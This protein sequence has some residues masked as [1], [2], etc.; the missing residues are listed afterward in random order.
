MNLTTKYLGFELRNPLIVSSCRLSEKIDN[1]V[2]MEK[3]GA[4]AITMY[5]IFE[6]EIKNTDEFNEYFLNL[7][8]ES[9]YEALTYFPKL[10]NKKSFLNQHLYHLAQAVK[11]VSIPIIGSLNA[12]THQGWIDYAVEMQN[13]GIKAL[14]LNLYHLPVEAHQAAD[15]EQ[16]QLQLIAELK[17][18]IQIPL[19][20]K[21]SPYYTSLK[22][23]V[24]KLDK[25]VHVDG[26]VLFNRFYYPQFDVKSFKF[27]SDIELSTSYEARLPM[28]WIALLQ[29][30]LA[31]SIAG[32]T[33]V[34]NSDDL[35]TYLLVG[36]DAVACASCLMQNGIGYIKVLLEGLEAWMKEHKYIELSQINRLLSMQVTANR[37][38]IE[39]AQYMEA[40]RSYRS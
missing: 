9:F 5:S 31:C 23:F 14:E 6:E 3:A 25:Q 13:T 27:H 4:G 17:K 24:S 7:G 38:A 19:A 39:R 35:L 32:S 1:I 18:K 37:L 12:I 36:A 28:R 40:L 16:Q 20:I 10:D 21:L 2:A 15:I 26:V 8:A 30:Q 29:N 22:D 33:G 34:H 11:S